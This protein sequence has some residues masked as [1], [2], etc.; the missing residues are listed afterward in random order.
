MG[1][2]L[3][4]SCTQSNDIFHKAL[5]KL[6]DAERVEY[7]TLRAFPEDEAQNYFYTWEELQRTQIKKVD[8]EILLNDLREAYE[9]G[10]SLESTPLCF[11]PRHVLR[12]DAKEKVEILI[13]F[14]CD[15]IKIHLGDDSSMRRI[16][17]ERTIFDK[18]AKKYN[19]ELD[20]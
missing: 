12:V 19:L 13:C 17:A 11:D 18:I 15:K 7:I 1:L 16:R 3:L 6:R 5:S 14:S 10:K 9:N 8:L 20:E 2:V 4:N